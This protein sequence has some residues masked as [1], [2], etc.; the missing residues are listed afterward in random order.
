VRTLGV[1]VD[2]GDVWT[3]TPGPFQGGVVDT[4]L[5]GTVM[6]FVPPIAAL[7]DAAVTFDGD[8]R[9]RDRP[10]WTLI[11]AL[12]Q[13]GVVID[14]A[15]RG[16][17]PFTVR[18][19]GSV[20]GGK[21]EVDASVSSQFVSAL[22]LAGARYDKGIDV[23]HVGEQNLVSVPHIEM[24]VAM[25]ARCGVDVTQP[26]PTSWHVAPGPIAAHD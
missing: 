25:L 19:Q 22:L 12:R 10:M 17:L 26:T 3:V 11:E 21:V 8:D 9:A 15:G 20:S 1:S 6:R 4:G 16:R 23:V 24:T 18:G 14:D 7:A 5:A 2:E 13:A